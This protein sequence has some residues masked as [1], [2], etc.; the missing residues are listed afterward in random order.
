MDEVSKA[1]PLYTWVTIM[2]YGGAPQGST[3]I[4]ATPK[5]PVKP[6]APGDTSKAAAAPKI[7]K[8]PEVETTPPRDNVM[9]RITGRTVDIQAMTRFMSQL[10]DSPFLSNV[11]L[12]RTTPSTEA[13]QY[14]QFQLIINYTRPDSL[15]IRRMPLLTA[16]RT[17]TAT[18]GAR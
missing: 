16:G 8:A 15:A 3:N 7:K 2:G 12:E 14:Y 4:V 18:G 1:L 6:K 13:D 17:S 9:V 10:E 5:P 11:Y